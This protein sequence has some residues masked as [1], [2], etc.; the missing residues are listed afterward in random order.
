[1]SFQKTF[2]WMRTNEKFYLLIPRS[3]AQDDRDAPQEALF[4]APTIQ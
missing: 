1:M 3:V 2:G 4:F